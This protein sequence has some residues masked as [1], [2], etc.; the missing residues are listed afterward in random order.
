[1]SKP[2]FTA[3]WVLGLLAAGTTGLVLFLL[4]LKTPAPS[5]ATT[6]AAS[7]P[8]PPAIQ[9]ER[10]P[11]GF[12]VTDH[13]LIT[14][15]AT[16]DLDQDGLLDILVCDA[17]ANRIGWIRQA[18]RGVFT[19]QFIG[20]PVQGPAHVSVCDLNKDGR[21][22]LLVASMGQVLPNN[23]RIGKVIVLE[24]LGEGRFRNRVLA[25]NIARVN[26]VR[27]ADL[28]GDGR[29]D[30]VVGQFGYLQGE[31]RWMENLGDWTFRSHTLLE[32]PGTIMT[33]VADFD[34]DGKMDFAALI[35]QD[36][37]QV[38]SQIHLFHNLGSGKFEDR[39][40]WKT[41]NLEY[42]SSGLTSDDLNG[43]GAP[44]LIFSNGDGFNSAFSALTPWH[45][46]QWFENSGNGAF[47]FH[48]IGDSL[49]CYSPVAVDLSGQGHGHLDIVTVS[50]F[51]N[52]LDA[53]AVM[54]TAWLNDG[55]E[56][57]T[58]VP[59]AYAPTRLLTVA[60][61]DL[62]GN[63]VPVLVTG[64]FHAYPPYSH[65]SRVTLWRRQ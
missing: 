11:V 17:A 22:D 37:S 2:V 25:E 51:N 26:D 56:H 65:M 46:L 52:S 23:D 59:L 40:V 42:G 39:V 47:V 44:D 16:A 50:A 31:I 5:P 54:M 29:I 34:R 8:P 18:P 7:A 1:M 41:T 45:G 36:S 13:P 58:P 61:G 60:A 32:M 27:G 64:G 63:G 57:F 38:Y 53:S 48:R 33:P 49:G 10:E 14:H 30:L 21:P 3:V 6:P 9:Y 15:V 19:E 55:H 12:P 24:N 28:N 4:L 62:D 20:E 43:D 35:S